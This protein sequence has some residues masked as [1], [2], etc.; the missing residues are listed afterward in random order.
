MKNGVT[1][2]NGAI[3]AAQAVVVKDVPAFSVVAGNPVKVVKMRFDPKTVER[4]EKIAWW[5]WDIE[6]IQKNLALIC[7]LDV[8]ALEKAL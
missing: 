7:S 6:K 5:N 4:L 1:I 3:V 8:E 2:G